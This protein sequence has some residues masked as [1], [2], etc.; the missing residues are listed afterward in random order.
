MAI[1][2]SF[3]NHK[4]GTAKTTST[5]NLGAALARKGKRVLLIDVDPQANLTAG[6]GVNEVSSSIYESLVKGADLPIITIKK[7]LDLVPSSLDLA[8]F[9]LEMGAEFSRETI[10]KRKIEPIKKNYDYILFDCP[11]NISLVT[12]NA[13]VAS[14]QV[15]IPLEAEFFAFRG[16]DSI[17]GI[18]QKVKTHLNENLTIKGVFITKCNPQRLLT[19]QITESVN[20][21]FGDKLFN[22]YIRINV[23]LS[24][25]Q[26]NGQDIFEYAPESNGAEDYENLCEE[27]LSK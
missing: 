7:N 3:V 22:T 25:A 16:I 5:L 15:L 6:L 8:A 14:D 9:E 10:I 19:K 27:I 26:A 13:L 23:A 20:K 4:G 12:I 17:V 11:P 21:H 1:V 18:I 24:E 2:Q